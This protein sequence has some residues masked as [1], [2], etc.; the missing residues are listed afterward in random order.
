MRNDD[1]EHRVKRLRR[2]LDNIKTTQPIGGD[3]WVPYK[4]TGTVS[5]PQGEVR[6]LI[7]TQDDINR[8]A[9]VRPEAAPQ[10]NMYSIPFIAQ[11]GVHVFYMENSSPFGI[12]KDY[13]LYSTMK[14]TITVETSPPF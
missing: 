12:N 14:G 4:Y 10:M 13:L 5:I 6:Y 11:N 8:P 3:S 1:I 7:F 9:V 2:E